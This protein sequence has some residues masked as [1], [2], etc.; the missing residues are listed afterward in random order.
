MDEWIKSRYSE[1]QS[2]SVNKNNSIQLPECPK[3]KTP[4]RLNLRYSNYIKKQ[5]S[6]MESIKSKQIG[7]KQGNE[8]LKNGLVKEMKDFEKTNTLE[9]TSIIVGRINEHLTTHK[10]MPH[11]K[12]VCLQNVFSI[13]SSLIKTDE[14]MLKKFKDKFVQEHLQCEINKLINQIYRAGK[15]MLVEN[16]NLNDLVRECDRLKALFKYYE[17]KTEAKKPINDLNKSTQIGDKLVKLEHLLFDKKIKKKD[18]MRLIVLKEYLCNIIYMHVILTRRPAE[19]KGS[20]LSR[21]MALPEIPKIIV[22]ACGSP[23]YSLTIQSSV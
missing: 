20:G 16:Q 9:I 13:F 3:C 10:N 18:I 8:A 22:I 21:G 4:I 2:E 15:I 5:L 14:E 17:A 6:A 12:I 19:G 7:D 23:A 11:N 1:T